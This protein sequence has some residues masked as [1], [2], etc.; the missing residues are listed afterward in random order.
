MG[1]VGMNAPAQHTLYL[2]GTGPTFWPIFTKSPEFHDSAP[3]PLDRWSM[4][5][6]PEIAC[7]LPVAVHDIVYPFGGPPYAPFLQWATETGEAHYSAVGMLVHERAGLMI[8]FRGGIIVKGAVDVSKP[9]SLVPCETSCTGQ[10]CASACPVA[11]L[12]ATDGYDVTA[13]HA[14]LDTAEGADCLRNGCRARRACPI[15]Q[16][17]G[18]DPAQS[19]FHMKS[20][21]P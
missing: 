1:M 7:Q 11:A 14:Y 19:A 20:F 6:V 4:R 15:S 8:S 18:R 12:S 2:L 17:F 21:H 3:D 5:V 13:C 16:Q 10:P 9:P